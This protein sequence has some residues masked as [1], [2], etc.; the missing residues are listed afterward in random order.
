MQFSNQP[1]Q[2]ASSL[3]CS[4]HFVMA[5]RYQ[6]SPFSRPLQLSRLPEAG[7]AATHNLAL[8]DQ[9][10]A[11]LGAVEGQVNVK[12]DTVEGALRRVHA[13]KVFFEVLA[14]Q[15]G[16]EGDDFLDACYC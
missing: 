14:R 3:T 15:V 4:L 5:L 13:L 16:R 1:A 6:C 12:V 10:G 11:K 2:H 8:A 7:A 9:L